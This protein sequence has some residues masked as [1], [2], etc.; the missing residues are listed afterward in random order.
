MNE[1]EQDSKQIP[2]YEAQLNLKPGKIL[3]DEDKKRILVPLDC[4]TYEAIK[5]SLH[6]F[7]QKASFRTSVPDFLS[8]IIRL[9]WQREVRHLEILDGKLRY[10]YERTVIKLDKNIP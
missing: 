6:E 2:N 1:Q 9:N 5:N 4:E 8:R 7:S 3:K 10:D